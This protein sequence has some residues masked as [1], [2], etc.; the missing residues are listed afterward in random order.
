MI[1]IT[2]TYSFE[3]KYISTIWSIPY[4]IDIKK[5]YSDFMV[6]KAWK[7]FGLV[8]NPEYFNVMNYKDYHANKTNLSEAEYKTT[9]NRWNKKV[10]KEWHVDRYIKEHIKTAIKLPYKEL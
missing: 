7:E 6:N 5:N 2:Y 9:R 10:L 3:T 4:D 1:Y 8:I